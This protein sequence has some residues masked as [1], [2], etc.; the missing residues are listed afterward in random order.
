MDYSR[1]LTPV[2]IYRPD[3]RHIKLDHN[4]A[5]SSG[6]ADAPFSVLYDTKS[7]DASRRLPASLTIYNEQVER[8]LLEYVLI[9]V[10]FFPVFSTS[11]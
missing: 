5:G 6:R 9:R 7:R 10:L 1:S 3:Y 11:T 8:R 4:L 2:V